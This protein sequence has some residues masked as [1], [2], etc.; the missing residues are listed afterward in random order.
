MASRP[1]AGEK[2]VDTGLYGWVRHPMYFGALF[3][4]AGTPLA[5]G[6]WWTLLLLP[7]FLVI[8]YFRITSE[9]TVLMR[10]LPGYTEYQ[11]RVKYRLI[12]FV[13]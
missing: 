12:P 7:I 6:S 8:L 4:I 3:L 10:D 11:T 1:Q 2:V 13:W 9:E 5:L